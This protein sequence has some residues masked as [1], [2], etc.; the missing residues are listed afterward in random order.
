[1][2]GLKLFPIKMKHFKNVFPTV[3]RAWE[4][5]L[6]LHDVILKIFFAIFIK[7]NWRFVHWNNDIFQNYNLCDSNIVDISGALFILKITQTQ[8][9]VGARDVNIIWV[10]E[11]I[12]LYLKS[13]WTQSCKKISLKFNLVKFWFLVNKVS[14]QPILILSRAGHRLAKK[15][16]IWHTR[17]TGMAILVLL[18]YICFIL[19]PLNMKRSNRYHSRCHFYFWS[20]AFTLTLTRFFDDFL[21][22]F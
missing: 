9:E 19:S 10:A 14:N 13:P 7:L 20:N 21:T 17:I 16:Y 11:I 15:P 6:D 22:I 1:M 4:L 2:V 18:S 3:W 12:W 8:F 5:A